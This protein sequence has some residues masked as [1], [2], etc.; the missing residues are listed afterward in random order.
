MVFHTV[1]IKKIARGGGGSIASS[2][3]FGKFSKKKYH[4]LRK[5]AKIRGFGIYINK[6]TQ[7]VTQLRKMVIFGQFCLQNII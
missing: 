2:G 7:K 4:F 6:F 5:N 1:G 3:Q